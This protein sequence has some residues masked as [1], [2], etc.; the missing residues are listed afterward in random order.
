MSDKRQQLA[1]CKRCVIKVGSSL[2]TAQGQGLDRNLIAAWVEQIVALRQQGI[3][4][5]LVS[6]GSVAEGMQRL[7]WQKRPSSV[8]E[9]QAAAAVG[10]MG[11]IQNYES[12]FLRHG[13][14]TAQIL[15]THED[16]SDR[17]RYLNSRSTMRTLL[18][19]NVVPVIN[20]N[21]T[22]TTEE[23]KF[24]DNDSLA[25]LV[26]NLIEADCLLLLTDQQGL[27]S[28]DPRV[29]KDAPIVH[30]ADAMDPKLDAMVGGA[31]G[32]FGSGGMFTKLRAARLA[33]RSGANTVIAYGRED[34]IIT[35]VLQAQ[36]VGTL[37]TANQQP[38]A[39]RKQWLAGHLKPHGSLHLDQGAIKVLRKD[40][41]SLLAVGVTKVSGQFRRGELV[42]CVDDKGIEVAR[43]LVNY[44]SVETDL[45]KGRPSSEI[46]QLL[47]YVDDPELIHRDNLVVN[48]AYA[49]S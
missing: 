2:L 32:Q 43:G 20:E 35:R 9:L 1:A 5:V 26:A 3:Q 23:I 17:R 41:K 18:Q 45:I 33:A 27:Y 38:V 40:G 25:A 4:V 46:Q 37:L 34:H 19:L 24:G 14:H 8:H 11:L 6:S 16:L 31:A 12:Q 29:N 21:D 28:T 13:I 44:S 36:T 7:G 30:E 15:L 22:V 49:D 10:Q 42:M 48:A 39:A 47:G